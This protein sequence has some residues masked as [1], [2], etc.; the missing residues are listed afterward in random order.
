[1]SIEVSIIIVNW[2]VKD[3]IISCINSIIKSK[4]E[5]SYEII[6]ADNAS[7]DGSPEAIEKRFP[8][9]IV[10]KNNSNPGF[11]IAN[12]QCFKIAK[13]DYI[14]ILNPDTLLYPDTIK[15]LLW[16]LKMNTSVWLVGPKLVFSNGEIQY[17]CARPFPSLTRIF[18]LEALRI[19][20]FPMIRELFLRRHSELHEQ[21]GPI[22]VDAVSGAAMF[23]RSNVLRKIGGFDEDFSFGGED[24]YL[25]FCV[26]QLGGEVHYLP[27]VIIT[28][29]HG[30][31]S[32]QDVIKATVMMTK[33]KETYFRKTEGKS[34]AFIYRLLI[35]F[36][37]Q[38]I[39]FLIQAFKFAFR[40]Q[41]LQY[42]KTNLQIIYNT[43]LWRV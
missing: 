23:I 15:M 18:F 2:N 8:N 21:N 43:I 4:I 6:V 7:S 31:S 42:T 38:P 26:K 25:C 30:A 14:F 11:A 24:I 33:S 41:S 37:Q 35:I 28:H 1:M 20:K 13:G 17:G 12:N 29:Y 9:V 27:N 3:L 40:K 10:I 5:F 16:Y 39:D 34:Y 32:N 19:N 22:S 36:V